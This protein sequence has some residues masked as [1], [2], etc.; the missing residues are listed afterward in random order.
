MQRE[1][2]KSNPIPAKM[3]NSSRLMGIA[4][5]DLRNP[6]S[7][8]L[9]ATQYLLE[10]AG[11]VLEQ[12]HIALLQSIES[13]SHLL[14]RLVEDMVEIA[15]IES[16][17]LRLNLQPT[18]VVALLN[19]YLLLNRFRA[20]LKQVRVEVLAPEAVPTV[21]LDSLKISR[22]IDTIVSDAIKSSPPGSRIEI[23]IA[24][25][26][27]QAVVSVKDDGETELTPASPVVIRIVE[28]HG[29]SIR[30]EPANPHGITRVL[31]LPLSKPRQ[32]SRAG[33][34]NAKAVKA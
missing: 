30:I 2:A 26:G 27:E 33:H 23:H 19:K 31:T 20:D 8:I 5:H 6:I 28:G 32:G 7:G 22:V 10:D 21:D 14:L 16:G 9:T 4:V 25:E 18:D 11:H 15:A 13:A 24:S 3:D 29:G 1:R 17:D 34:L 12:E